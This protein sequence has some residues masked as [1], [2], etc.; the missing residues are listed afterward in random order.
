MNRLFAIGEEVGLDGFQY[1]K[2]LH[3]NGNNA[4]VISFQDISDLVETTFELN[5]DK[6]IRKFD[7]R[8]LVDVDIKH[9]GP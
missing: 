8:R 9:A 5:R 2:N 1:H 3:L 7:I 6:G 4:K